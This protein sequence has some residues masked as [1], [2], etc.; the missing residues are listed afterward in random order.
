MDGFC[1]WVK[2]GS[3][4]KK[5]P[6]QP[7]PYRENQNAIQLRTQHGWQQGKRLFF[8]LSPS[9]LFDLPVPCSI[10]FRAGFSSLF[11]LE[12]TLQ[13]LSVPR[14]FADSSF[15]YLSARFSCASGHWSATFA[16][17]SFFGDVQAHFA[18]L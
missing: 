10:S 17:L 18:I 3:W 8:P 9:F 7:P 4:R 13:F 15:F 1:G 5:S 2:I 12:L 6:S 14:E 11:S 16:V